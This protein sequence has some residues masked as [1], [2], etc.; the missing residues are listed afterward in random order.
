MYTILR[1]ERIDDEHR[2]LIGFRDGS[3]RAV[4]VSRT[5]DEADVTSLIADFFGVP[6][7]AITTAPITVPPP[8]HR[9]SV[10]AIPVPKDVTEPQSRAL[11]I[12]RY[13]GEDWSITAAFDPENQIW[14]VF[15]EPTA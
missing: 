6:A 13:R 11:P 10:P 9:I 7:T 14:F 4:T 3:V 8:G 12:S 15:G 1:Q 5:V 2:W